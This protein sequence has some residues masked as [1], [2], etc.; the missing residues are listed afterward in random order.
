VAQFWSDIPVTC[1]FI[2]SD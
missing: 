1:G 2:P